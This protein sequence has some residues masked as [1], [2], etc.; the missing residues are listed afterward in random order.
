MNWTLFFV[1]GGLIPI[2]ASAHIHTVKMNPDQ[3]LLVHTA[4]GIAT[5]VEAPEGIQSAIIG[6]QSGFKIEYFDHAVTIK[7]LRASA[8]TNLYLQ[9]QTRRYDLR[10]ETTRQEA[11]DYIV[12]LKVNDGRTQVVWHEVS[13]SVTGKVLILKCARIANLPQGQI[14]LDL[15]ILSNAKDK[16]SPENIFL[17]QGAESKVINGI[18]LSKLEISKDH[19]TMLGMTLLKSDLV[20]NRSIQISVKSEHE[21]VDLTLPEDILWK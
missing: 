16:I 12:Y 21:S 5:I 20:K 10:L 2:I 1:M 17:R 8:R 18:F 15:K 13:K 3:I 7:P 4:L 14:L 6:D 11:A 9:T 19:P